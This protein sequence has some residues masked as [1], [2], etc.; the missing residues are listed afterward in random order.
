MAIYSII[1]TTLFAQNPVVH[2]APQLKEQLAIAISP[3]DG[4][5]YWFGYYDKLLS[6]PKDRYVLAMRT[7]FAYQALGQ[8]A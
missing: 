8:N 1:A 4:H 3:D 2:T 5:Y 7:N 6:D